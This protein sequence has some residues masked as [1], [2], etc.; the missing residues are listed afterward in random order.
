MIKRAPIAKVIGAFLI[1]EKLHPFINFR[2]Q[3][4]FLT[5]RKH[6]EAIYKVGDYM[7]E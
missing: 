2:L 6:P 7:K 3:I 1:T 5:I 4:A